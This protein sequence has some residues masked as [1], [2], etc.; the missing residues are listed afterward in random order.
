MRSKALKSKLNNKVIS[1]VTYIA[2][3]ILTLCLMISIINGDSKTFFGYTFRIVVTG[4]MEPSIKVNSVSIIKTCNIDD[5]DVGD[6]A[7]F[8]Y[9]QDIIHRV[10]EKTTNENGELI[11]HTKGDANEMPDSVEINSDMVVG[12]VV[13]TFN[14]LAPIIDK[15]SITPGQFDSMLFA[16]NIVIYGI[17]VILV[18]FTVSWLISLILTIIKSFKQKDNL[19]KTLDILIDDI[20]DLIIYK[21]IL[22]ELR[23]TSNNNIKESTNKRFKLD[24]NAIGDKIAKAKIEMEIRAFHSEVNSFKNNIKNSLCIARICSMIKEE[25][26]DK[27]LKTISDIIKYTKNFNNKDT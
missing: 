20:D 16:R 1:A 2:L 27:S 17:I 3:I 24:I 25:Q 6:I 21:E 26:K 10:I 9:S 23:E 11:I 5:L 19:Y 14:V 15:Y 22:M 12:K 18:V 4:S 13:K 7:C 8:N